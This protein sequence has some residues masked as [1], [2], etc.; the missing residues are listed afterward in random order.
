[1]DE[2]ISNQIL[3]VANMFPA[4]SDVMSD[5]YPTGQK[6]NITLK[7]LIVGGCFLALLLFIAYKSKA[8]K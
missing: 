1:M 4:S 5:L 2:H 6:N 8:T 3:T 7:L